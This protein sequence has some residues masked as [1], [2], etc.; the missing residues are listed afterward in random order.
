[1]PTIDTSGWTPVDSTSRCDC[2]KVAP[3]LAVMVPHEGMRDTV[4]TAREHVAWQDA[5][6]KEQGHP[7]CVAIFMDR[8]VD[9]EAAARDVYA[10][11]TDKALTL[12][13]AL[14]GSTFWG[15][16]IAAVYTGLKKPPVPTRFFGTLEDA[17]PW[18]DE[19]TRAVR[20]SG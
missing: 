11:E 9:Q 7:G 4:D 13:Y 8:I 19:M 17:M 20:K 3:T 10:Q 16:A 6:W 15:R 12:G 2:Y 1:M 14:I 5:Y 18:V